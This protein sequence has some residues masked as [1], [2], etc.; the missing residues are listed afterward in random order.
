[1]GLGDGVG[2][3]KLWR[4]AAV[5]NVIMQYGTIVFSDRYMM[6]SWFVAL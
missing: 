2:Q 5:A 1:M 3:G 6:V 4:L